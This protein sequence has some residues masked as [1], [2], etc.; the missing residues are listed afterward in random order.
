MHRRRLQEEAGVLVAVGEVVRRD[1]LRRPVVALDRI[2]VR[3]HHRD[4]RVE[5][6]LLADRSLGKAGAPSRPEDAEEESPFEDVSATRLIRVLL[7]QFKVERYQTI[8]PLIEPERRIPHYRHGKERIFQHYLGAALVEF[9]ERIIKED[10]ADGQWFLFQLS[11]ER[12]S[13]VTLPARLPEHEAYARLKDYAKHLESEVARKDADAGKTEEI[14]RDHHA[15]EDERKRE[16]VIPPVKAVP[17]L[18]H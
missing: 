3:R 6:G 9:G 13:E 17:D 15:A 14:V 2:A 5:P 12:P 18:N 1:A 16:D 10:R 7:E 4:R 8:C 11:P